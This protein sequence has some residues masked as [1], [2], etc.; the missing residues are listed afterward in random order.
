[1]HIYIYL[2]F[3]TKLL[4][5]RKN[6]DSNV[7]M[8]FWERLYIASSSSSSFFLLCG[9]RDRIIGHFLGPRVIISYLEQVL[10]IHEVTSIFFAP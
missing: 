6:L 9:T 4:I 10:A 7:F 5:F 2:C 8:S 1:M 3:G